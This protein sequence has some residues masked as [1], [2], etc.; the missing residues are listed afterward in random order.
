MSKETTNHFEGIPDTTPLTYFPK[1][2]ST[3]EVLKE[4]EARPELHELYKCWKPEH[5]QLFLAVCTG[6]RGL[7]AIYDGVFKEI[8]NPEITPERLEAFLSLILKRKVKIKAVLP[9]DGVRLGDE[10][11]LIYT[12]IVVELEDGTLCNVEIQKIGYAF[13]G[14][15]GACYSSDHLLRQYKKVRGER[16]RSF[17]Y[18]DIRKVYTIVFFEHSAKDFH[19]FPNH[20][21]HWFRQQSD[22]G[23]EMD[24]LQEYFYICLDIFRNNM[25]NKSVSNDM[26]AWLAFLSFDDPKRILELITYDKKFKAMYQD[27]YELCLNT[28]R[29]MQVFS[30]E[31]AILDRNTVRYMMDEMQAELDEKAK[32]LQAMNDEL[33]LKDNEL[34]LKDDQLQLKD[35]QLQQK[36]DQLQLKD[37]QLQLKDDQLQQ[38]DNQLQQKDDQLQQK[39]DQ[40]Q[41]KDNQLQQKDDE[42]QLKDKLIQ[43]LQEKLA[44][45]QK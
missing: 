12:D 4:L 20:Y 5:Q 11:T 41:Q 43:Q 29:V 15:R 19:R 18:Q 2:H 8:F 33:Q 35:N 40:L 42:L 6:T 7:K 38:K 37:N 22:T 9:N 28:E 3:E 10:S 14:A 44:E 27:M 1:L 17:T 21:I 31:L 13:P 32:V 25:E 34:Q 30:K 16:G 26:E 39:D 23:L 36:D 45:L 24:M